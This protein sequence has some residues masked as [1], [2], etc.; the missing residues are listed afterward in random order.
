M[1]TLG[2]DLMSLV[3]LLVATAIVLGL[4]VGSSEQVNGTKTGGG[5]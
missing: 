5:Y 2:W 1:T 4:L 3:V